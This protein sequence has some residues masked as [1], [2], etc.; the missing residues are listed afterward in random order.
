MVDR[1]SKRQ[2]RQTYFI[3]P[4]GFRMH[5]E[6]KYGMIKQNENKKKMQLLNK[7]Y[8]IVFAIQVIQLC[9]SFPYTKQIEIFIQKKT[10]NV[11]KHKHKKKFYLDIDQKKILY[12]FS[13]F[14]WNGTPVRKHSSD[15]NFFFSNK[16]VIDSITGLPMSFSVQIRF[17][18]LRMA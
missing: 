11:S 2:Y 5:S 9:A 10:Y 7:F 15:D 6:I 3:F 18:Y 1:L 8:H 13:L 17:L 12:N 16:L 14:L 4:R